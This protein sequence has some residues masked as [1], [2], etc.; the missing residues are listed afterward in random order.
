MLQISSDITA[1]L[2]KLLLGEAPENPELLDAVNTGNESLTSFIGKHYFTDY[3]PQGGSKIK[4]ITGRPGSGK[5]HLSRLLCADADKNGYLTVSFSA[6]NV[7]LYDFRE[8]YL[9]ILRQCDIEKVLSGCADAIIRSMDYDPAQV[10]EGKAFMD[11]LSE[12]GEADALSRSEIRTALRSFFTKN[13]R[14]DNSFACCCSLLTG[15]ILGHPVLEPSNRELLLKYLYGDK[16]VKLS[17]L[18]ALG[19]SPS[20]ITKYNARHLLRS[21]AET[22]HLGGYSGLLICVDDMEQVAAKS[23]QGIIKYTKLR[24]DDTY[25][26]IRQLIDDIDSMR[27]IMFLFACGR[28]LIDNES[29]GFKSYPALWMRIQNE[30]VGSRFNHFAD[31][32]DLDRY[33]DQAYTPYILC[34]MSSALADALNSSAEGVYSPIGEE[35]ALSL[36]DRARY[37][38]LGLPYLV[39]RAVVEGCDDHA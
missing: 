24:R 23:S 29:S 32:L 38:A 18:R 39:N 25:E 10:G 28:E 31:I 3:L 16:T 2:Q 36:T 30:V 13:P 20:R 37:G 34:E 26:S 33:A 7:C 1:S 35:T 17:Q 12:K 14:L 4:F 15:S 6:K 9:E 19:L 11:Y 27:Y 21:L 22:V 8:I 5:T